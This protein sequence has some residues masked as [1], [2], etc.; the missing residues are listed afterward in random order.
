[1]ADAKSEASRIAQEA[2]A[3]VDSFIKRRTSQ[4]ETRIAQ[5]EVIA[6]TEVR[7]AAAD[8]AIRAAEVILKGQMAGGAGQ[9]LIAA[10]LAEVKAKLN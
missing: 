3:A 2:E 9:N 6:T 1:M 10:G 7:A 4:A 8:A 5:A